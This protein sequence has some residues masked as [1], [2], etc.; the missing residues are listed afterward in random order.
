MFEDEALAILPK[1][2]LAND[3]FIALH[4]MLV[5]INPLAP[6]KAPATIRTLLLITKPAAEAARPE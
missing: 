3:L 2:T 6:T 4:I 5:R 1:T